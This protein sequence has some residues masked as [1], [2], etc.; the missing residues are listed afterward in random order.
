MLHK[1]PHTVM[2]FISLILESG[3]IDSDTSGLFLGSLVDLAILHILG[4]LLPGEDFGDC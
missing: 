2:S 1:K 3:C 4:V